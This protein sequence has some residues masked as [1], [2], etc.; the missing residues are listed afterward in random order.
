MESRLTK[1]F[2]FLFGVMGVSTLVGGFLLNRGGNDAIYGVVVICVGFV[3][4]L[5]GSFGYLFAPLARERQIRVTGKSQIGV[6]LSCDRTKL[7]I[8]RRYPLYR[9]ALKI[10]ET[11][12]AI[13]GEITAL[14]EHEPRIGER[15]MI[16][17]ETDAWCIELSPV[18]SEFW[19]PGPQPEFKLKVSR[20]P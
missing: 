19:D 17:R 6:V 3:I 16:R 9:V 14:P 12:D 10:E 15:I 13:E 11:G 8:N 20:R 1:F 18:P 5:L 2:V 7:V 4:A